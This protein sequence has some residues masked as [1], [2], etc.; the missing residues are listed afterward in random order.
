MSRLAP[1]PAL[2]LLA[3]ISG[4][5]A[6]DPA[7]DLV[8]APA[9]PTPKP[10][11]APAARWAVLI[12]VD[13]YEDKTI[14][15]LRFSAN[16]AHTLAALLVASG[17]WP[18]DHIILLTP[19]QEDPDLRP[20]RANILRTLAW[21][22]SLQGADTLLLFFSG[23][24]G[25]TGESG[26]STN[27]LYPSDADFKLPADTGIS[28]DRVFDV[29]EQAD[30]QRRVVIVDA[31][32][33]RFVEAKAVAAPSWDAPRYRLSQGTMV[34]YG[35][36]PGGYSYEDEEAELG[37]LTRALVEGLQGEADGQLDPADGMVGMNELY[38]FAVE[39]LQSRSRKSG[40]VQ[41]PYRGG[42]W[43]G[44]DFALLPV[45]AAPGT[46]SARNT[47]PGVHPQVEW[48]ALQD[49][50]P[51]GFVALPGGAFLRGGERGFEHDD[52]RPARQILLSPFYLA[53]SELTG[54]QWRAV[55]GTNHA[56]WE[57]EDSADFPAV[58]TWCG[59]LRLANR[60]SELE[61]GRGLDPVYEVPDDCERSG[62]A[63]WDRS[64]RGYRLPTEAEWEYAARAG[65]TT[66]FFSGDTTQA[67]CT[68][69]NVRDQTMRELFPFGLFAD[70]RDGSA[71][72][73][74]V[75]SFEP[76]PFGLYDVY[77]NVAEWVWDRY[78]GAAYESPAY[79]NPAG[80]DRAASGGLPVFRGG[81]DQDHPDEARSGRRRYA[82]PSSERGVRL[83][84][85]GSDP[86]PALDRAQAEGF[87]RDYQ[88]RAA[89]VGELLRW[90]TIPAGAGVAG[91]P[92]GGQDAVVEIVFTEPFEMLATEVSNAQY[93]ALYYWH[94]PVDDKPAV[95]IGWDRAQAF[96][97]AQG[98]RLPTELE[99]EYA[100]RAG[101]RT[102]WPA[103]YDSQV[104]SDYEWTQGMGR[105]GVGLL[106]TN[107]WGLHDMLGNAA[108]W[109]ADAYVGK[110]IQRLAAHGQPLVDPPMLDGRQVARDLGR[111]FKGGA[112]S[113]PRPSKRQ[114]AHP[115][116]EGSTVVGFRCVRGPERAVLPID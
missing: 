80:P 87:T 92:S 28:L 9:S 115:A 53:E 43:T 12:G 59:A 101:S 109:V 71:S 68:Y 13:E 66:H 81:G 44:A 32:R 41:V 105:E 36:E 21:A 25:S 5:Q 102:N 4:A 60:M 3:G 62:M 61:R 84:L 31:C 96:C 99:W 54:R 37:A 113:A 75:K 100:A 90:V 42:E 72:T 64:L 7:K 65:T 79:L 73:V 20:T 39:R 95:K 83:A 67:L 103:G 58:A 34:L 104:L 74:A 89:K 29:L 14:S 19:D 52:E 82:L 69:D 1:L 10:V 8:R 47:G 112:G 30:A 17:A 23:H 38:A 88:A 63:S 70:C 93:T 114:S 24:G 116:A 91:D 27:V 26:S 86:L 111:T 55:I 11:A 16:D 35:T 50:S 57:G 22:R 48:V 110:A 56:A 106:P 97:H 78:D 51:L 94:A 108:E 46:F 15:D 85:D 40:R 98:G 77:G 6:K 49:Q 33:N 2:I 76:S 18:A 107:A 45:T